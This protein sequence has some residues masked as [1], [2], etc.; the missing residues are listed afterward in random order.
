MSKPQHWRT[1]PIAFAYYLLLSFLPLVILLVT[2]GS[3]FVQRDA[4]THGV[5]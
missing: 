5:R 2:A 1:P 3:L 4:A